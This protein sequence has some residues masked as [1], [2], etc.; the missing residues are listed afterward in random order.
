M[1]TI[2]FEQRL[3]SGDWRT[4]DSEWVSFL[5]AVFADVE[6]TRFAEVGVSIANTRRLLALL[7]LDQR[8]N[9]QRD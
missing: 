4:A 5:N 1:S 2:E 9:G 7:A 8:I 3:L 6:M